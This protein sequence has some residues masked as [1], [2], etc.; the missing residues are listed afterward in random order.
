M[1]VNLFLNKVT[2]LRYHNFDA[3]TRE[4]EGSK[5]RILCSARHMLEQV[6]ED[7]EGC[8]VSIGVMMLQKYN[9]L[10]KSLS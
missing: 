6:K 9:S 7:E 3:W 5:E 8:R 2:R 10:I 4:M 1:T